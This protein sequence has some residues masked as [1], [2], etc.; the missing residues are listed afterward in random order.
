MTLAAR[1]AIS[2]L[3]AL[4][5]AMGIGRFA[6]TP[7]LPMMQHDHGLTLAQGGWLASSNYAGYLVGALYAMRSQLRPHVAILASL[8]LISLSTLAAAFTSRMDVL[9]A[10]RFVPGFASALVLVYVSAWSIDLLAKARRAELGALV[11]SGVGAGIVCA[12]L[13][14]LVLVS[15]S[16]ASESAW[17]ALG[18][19]ALA[20][21]A[22]IA[23]TVWRTR[24]AGREDSK[25]AFSGSFARHW[26]LIYAQAAFGFGYIIPATFLPVMA[27]QALGDTPLF[28]WAWP[29]FGAAAA[30]STLLYARVARHFSVRGAW[31]TSLLV[32]AAGV[33][34]PVVVPG[35][36]GIVVAAIAVGS[37]FMV[38]TML[39][40]QEAR[41]A[42]GEGARSLMGAMTTAFALGQI[43]GPLVAAAATRHHAGFGA[44]LVIAALPLLLAAYFLRQ[45]R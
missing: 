16:A 42:A 24:E 45:R 1:A 14:C 5:V 18:A 44:V 33:G 35:I 3:V 40:M 26:R 27:K 13:L 22:A 19:I 41:R 8:A 4:A 12:G 20:A 6:F 15:I 9:L 37:T 39:A 29:V 7:L 25:A 11:F 17:I 2:G 30:A 31:A 21:S 10:L 36:A 38:G 43:A 34:C 23:P 28:G 32:M